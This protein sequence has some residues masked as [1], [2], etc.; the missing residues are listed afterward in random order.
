MLLETIK[1]KWR[2][3]KKWWKSNH[4]R[5]YII[6]CSAFLT[7]FVVTLGMGVTHRYDKHH[8]I[9]PVG[10]GT[11]LS[12]NKLFLTQR[13]YN[14]NQH[15]Y[16]LDFY[17]TS[18]SDGDTTNQ[19]SADQFSVQNV[20]PND[21]AKDL[22][23]KLI[24]VTPQ[25]YVMYVQHV[26]NENMRTEIKYKA[27]FA[28]GGAS[29]SS[30]TDTLKVYS[31]EEKGTKQ[32]STLTLNTKGNQLKGSAI[33][34]NMSLIRAKKEKVKKDI[35]KAQSSLEATQK[36]IQSIQSNLEFRVGEEKQE[37]LERLDNLKNQ[38]NN[39]QDTI[40]KDQD[41]LKEYDKQLLLLKEQ[42]TLTT[43]EKGSH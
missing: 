43:G 12:G 6:I 15:L 9:M 7:A 17:V 4:K 37:D 10:K 5:Q 38:Q 33:D 2:Y 20:S 3:L 31:S 42:K 19:Y 27:S 16:R 13:L 24:R 21:P 40:Q 30:E 14:P 35:K 36:E 1:Q 8:S 11:E 39:T 25:Y 32:D 28:D 41:Q 29:D 18:D 22:P 23:T 26:P 34:Y